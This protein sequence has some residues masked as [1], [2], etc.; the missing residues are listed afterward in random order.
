[1]FRR[2]LVPLKFSTSSL[3]AA[4]KASELAGVHAARL[5]L[6]HAVD[7]RCIGRESEAECVN[8]CSKAAE[9][10]EKEIRSGL[11]PDVDVEFLCYPA[12]PAMEACRLA[13]STNVDLIVIGGHQPSG[14][15]LGRVDYTGMTI[16][17]KAPCAVL[18]FPLLEE[19]TEPLP[20]AMTGLPDDSEAE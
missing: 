6:F 15:P 2:I 16:M 17:E 13:R 7:Y 4:R 19:P 20:G 1:M 18:L 10:F 3:Q 8:A 9:R 12:D 14:H 5:I 11:A